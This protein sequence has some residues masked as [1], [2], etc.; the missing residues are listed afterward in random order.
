MHCI[1]IGT[2]YKVHAATGGASYILKIVRRNLNVRLQHAASRTPRDHPS[3][4]PDHPRTTIHKHDACN[5]AAVLIQLHRSCVVI[6]RR[7]LVI[8]ILLYLVITQD[9]KMHACPIRTNTCCACPVS[10]EWL[11]TVAEW[12]SRL[13][14]S[15]HGLRVSERT[16]RE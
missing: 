11:G 16:C 12:T 7:H 14:Q 10:S 13:P 5:R 2:H 6:T 4:V 9:S 15:S 3:Y 8:T 1:A